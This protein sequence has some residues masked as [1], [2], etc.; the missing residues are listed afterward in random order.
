[1]AMT[2]IPAMVSI[3]ANLIVSGVRTIETIPAVYRKSVEDYINA[4]KKG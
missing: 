4:Q 1:M 2:V 3:Y